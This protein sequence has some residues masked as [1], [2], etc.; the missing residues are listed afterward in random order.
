MILS[1][2]CEP[3]EESLPYTEVQ[4]KKVFPTCKKQCYNTFCLGTTVEPCYFKLLRETKNSLKLWEFKIADSRLSE[5]RIQG[6]CLWVWNN[7]E[8]EIIEFEVTGFN[9]TSNN[10]DNQGCQ[11]YSICRCLHLCCVH[12]LDVIYQTR[13]T[14]FHQDIQTLTRELKILQAAEYFGQ[15]FRCLES[16]WNTTSSGWCIC[17][18][19]KSKE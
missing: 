19:N 18:Q 5:R 13:E 8:F 11:K 2:W 9:Y 15:T 16:W 3:L 10:I 7:N 1:T 17:S 12:G 6:K 4:L 14:V